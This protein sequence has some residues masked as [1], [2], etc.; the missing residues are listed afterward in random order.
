MGINLKKSYEQTSSAHVG[1]EERALEE[2][3]MLVQGSA[4]LLSQNVC[5]KYRATKIFGVKTNLSFG[6]E[7][8]SRDADL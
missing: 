3:V 6:I 7:L 8:N 2:Y 5:F 1:L 4:K